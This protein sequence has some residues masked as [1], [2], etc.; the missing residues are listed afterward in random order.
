MNSKF[1]FFFLMIKS[2]LGFAWCF[3]VHLVWKAVTLPQCVSQF[4][5]GLEIFFSYSIVNYCIIFVWSSFF[6]THSNYLHVGFPDFLLDIH[7]AIS[8]CFAFFFLWC[9]RECYISFISLTAV[10]SAQSCYLI[11]ISYN[12]SWSQLAVFP[13]YPIAS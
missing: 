3:F 13:S 7:H 11:F 9:L 2:L 8:C 10:S 6:F 1:N 12:L 5:F 4:L